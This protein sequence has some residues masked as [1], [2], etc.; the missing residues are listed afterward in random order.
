MYRLIL[1]IHKFQFRK[2]FH[3]KKKFVS[4]IHLEVIQI[5]YYFTYQNYIAYIHNIKQSDYLHL[6]ENTETYGIL[7]ENNLETRMKSIIEYLLKDIERIY[8]L[9][10]RFTDDDEKI[11]KED[12]EYVDCITEN[13]SIKV[14]YRNIKD[15]IVYFFLYIQ[16]IQINLPYIILNYC[17]K[18]MQIF[19]Q[20]NI[21]EFIIVP[22][23]IYVKENLGQYSEFSENSFKMTTYDNH[24][25]ELKYNLINLSNP[26]SIEKI[27]D[28]VIEE[29]MCVEGL[30]H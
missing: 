10:N 9:I 16:N 27:R 30:K 5:L 11:E 15:N 17:I 13:K 12:L 18:I 1:Y 24:I 28:T 6:G 3:I 22:I 7:Q 21:E 19:K 4:W 25:L 26:Y 8:F 14:I 20:E 23:V 2:N 29:L